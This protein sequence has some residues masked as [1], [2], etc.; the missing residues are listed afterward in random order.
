MEIEL[1]RKEADLWKI[2]DDVITWYI[3]VKTEKGAIESLLMIQGELEIPLF[4]RHIKA[5]T[6]VM[7]TGEYRVE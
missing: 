3:I 7:E 2:I 1:L 6:K 5:I 4:K